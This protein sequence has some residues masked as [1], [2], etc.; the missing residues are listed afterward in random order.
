MPRPLAHGN[1]K[2]DKLLIG[3]V[4]EVSKFHEKYHINGRGL[5]KKISITWQQAKEIIKKCPTCSLYNQILLPAGSNPKVTNRNDIWHMD[6]FYF[7]GSGKQRYVYHTIDMYSGFQWATALNS[8][9]AA[10]VITHLLKIMGIMGITAQIKTDNV[11]AYVS[12]KIQQLF[13]YYNTK[14]VTGIPHNP[15]GQVVIERANHTLKEMLIKEKGR[16]KTPRN[17]LMC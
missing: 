10:C 13:T 15:T 11:P 17:R 8:E 2:I 1:D 9:K 4:L 7:A 12:N 5:K 14:H 16:A 6:V 3:N